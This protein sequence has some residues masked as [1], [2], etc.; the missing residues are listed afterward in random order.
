MDSYRFIT[1]PKVYTETEEFCAKERTGTSNARLVNLGN[2]RFFIEDERNPDNPY[3]ERFIGLVD[4]KADIDLDDIA[5]APLLYVADDEKTGQ[6]IV[7]ATDGNNGLDVNLFY[8]LVSY[9]NL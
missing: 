4:P 6:T 2:G 5:S 1:I 9:Y 8:R 7:I 3:F